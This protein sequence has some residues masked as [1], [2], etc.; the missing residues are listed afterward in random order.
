MKK[1]INIIVIIFSLFLVFNK[2]EKMVYTN[3][4]SS[5]NIYLGATL[6][7]KVNSLK[8]NTQNKID[9]IKENSEERKEERQEKRAEKKE[10]RQE[11]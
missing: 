5:N 10:Q 7:E 2:E 1:R 8:E 3:S 11:N 6:K 9:E 4:V